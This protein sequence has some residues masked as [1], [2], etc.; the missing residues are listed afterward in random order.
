METKDISRYRRLGLRIDELE[1][2]RK[3]LRDSIVSELGVGSRRYGQWKV[4]VSETPEHTV[5]AYTVRA[6]RRVTVR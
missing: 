1:K 6:G 3:S 2:E 4:T 5:Q